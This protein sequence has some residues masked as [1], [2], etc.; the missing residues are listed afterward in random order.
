MNAK[1]TR[2][3]F[4]GS[5]VALPL[6][7][8]ALKSAAE[9]TI[10]D[11]SLKPRCLVLWYEKPASQ[12]VE[13]L[14]IGNGRLG[15]M[16]FGGAANER[17]QLNEDTLYAGGPY[18][19]NNQEA[20]QALPEARK[21]IFEGRYKEANDLIGAKMMAHP[22][23][24]MHYETVGDLKLEFPNLLEAQN[25][26][27]ELDLETA[28][29]RVSYDSGGVKFTREAFASPVDQ[30]IV[31]HIS[32]GHSKQIS[33]VAS[34]DTPQKAEITSEGSDMLV[35]RGVN[36]DDAGI[37]GALKIQSRV[38]V[39]TRGGKVTAEKDRILVANADSAMLLIAAATSYVNYKDTSG[40]PEILTKTR[41]DAACR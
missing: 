19:P 16:V 4:I 17:L 12:W 13:A 8:S 30:V 40:S 5:A 37:K 24:Q 11:P 1:I 32:D 2:R 18:D 33:F 29:A 23:S 31:V 38:R 20:L 26:R 15:A 22:I 41:I 6:V 27:R 39:L 36:G 28:I 9:K 14:P 35:M 10:K 34:M 21:L 25:Y 3:K 7:P